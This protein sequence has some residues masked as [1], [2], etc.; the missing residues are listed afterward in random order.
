MMDR[1]DRDVRSG[2]RIILLSWIQVVGWEMD[3]SN[4]IECVG[5]QKGEVFV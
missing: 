3:L 5:V 4:H 2:I 1:S